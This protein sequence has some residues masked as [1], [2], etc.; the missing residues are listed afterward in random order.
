MPDDPIVPIDDPRLRQPSASILNID[1]EIRALAKYM[2]QIM[3]RE[4]GAGLAA[5][6]IGVPKR[7]IVVDVPDRSGRQHRMALI[8]PEILT[9]SADTEINLEGCLSMPGYDLPVERPASVTIRFRD[10]EGADRELTADGMLAVCLQHEID[11]VNGKVFSDRVSRLR[12]EK[13]K[14]WF[15]KVRRAA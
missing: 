5:I 14:A 1:D 11:H 7:M 12:R 8:N 6:Q 13:A 10:L 9:A 4:Y 2:F 15:A 3:D